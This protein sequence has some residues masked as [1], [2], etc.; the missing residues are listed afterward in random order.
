VE[1]K[2]TWH[3]KLVRKVMKGKVQ[4]YLLQE[5]FYFCYILALLLS[6]ELIKLMINITKHCLIKNTISSGLV[7]LA[8]YPKVI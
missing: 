8:D 3:L 2:L 7:I 6:K 4:I 1:L 5:S